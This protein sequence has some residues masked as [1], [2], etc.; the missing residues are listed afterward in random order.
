MGGYCSCC[1]G[2]PLL[3]AVTVVAVVM[4]RRVVQGA[5]CEGAF[6]V[7]AAS[8]AAGA[9]PSSSRPRRPPPLPTH[10]RPT[11]LLARS[12][13]VEARGSISV[14]LPALKPKQKVVVAESYGGRDEP[15][16]ALVQVRVCGGI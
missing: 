4:A 5:Q 11:P 14:V 3:L 1:V 8:A 7:A 2:L 13:T 6:G 12:P 10:P 15:V 16:D 9:A